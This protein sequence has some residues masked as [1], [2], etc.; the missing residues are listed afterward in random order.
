MLLAGC[1]PD[2]SPPPAPVVPP[3]VR[4]GSV[5]I[6]GDDTLAGVLSWT[7]PPVAIEAGM[8]AQAHLRAQAAL[9]AGDLFETADS[10]I[11]LWL[12]LQAR[13]PGD[14]AAA[15]GLARARAALR[16]QGEDALARADEDLQALRAAQRRGAVAQRLWPREAEVADFQRRV[17]LAGRVWDLNARGEAALAV[18]ALDAP[19][20]GALAAF[21]QALALAPG[22]ARARQ[23]L[24][25]VE[26]AYL[27]RAELAAQVSGDFARA[28]REVERAGSVRGSP[29]TI[30]DGSARIE[31]LRAQRVRRLRDEGL[32][33]L[34]DADGLRLARVRLEELLQICLLYTSP[35]PRD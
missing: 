8:E 1:K 21:R 6:S 22:Q 25:A 27:R 19:D 9:E 33:A 16:T 31:Q 7:P 13:D 32:V 3:S 4:A 29:Q 20:G 11:P 26:S 34:G 17:D 14:A 10:A 5:S 28:R 30:A 35:S 15:A 12:A 18:D 24:A 2:G 23:G